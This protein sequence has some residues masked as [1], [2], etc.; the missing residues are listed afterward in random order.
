MSVVAL[1]ALVLCCL[2]AESFIA[3]NVHSTSSRTN[4]VPVYI[5][6]GMDLQDFDTLVC[7]SYIINVC[8]L[9]R[10]WWSGYL[11]NGLY[12]C[13]HISVFVSWSFIRSTCN[14]AKCLDS[15]IQVMRIRF[16]AWN[17][18]K[19]YPLWQTNWTALTL[20]YGIVII[21][22]ML[23]VSYNLACTLYVLF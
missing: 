17:T 11:H 22:H 4:D 23:L 2:Y 8:G 5:P 21:S 13:L 3:D 7:H 10:A 19:S 1:L 18:S 6:Q 12:M 14:N 15:R 16:D 20:F 9:K